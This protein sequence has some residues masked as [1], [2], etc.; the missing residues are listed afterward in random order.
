MFKK[1]CVFCQISSDLENNDKVLKNGKKVFLLPDIKP[2]SQGHALIITK[3]H[4]SDLSASS[5]EALEEA[6]ILA[7]E[8]ANSLLKK[9]P[10]IKGFNYIS[11]QGV[12]AK[13]VVFHFHLHVIPRW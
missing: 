12:E 13:Q 6:I 10:E 4:F 8:Y 1:D 9:H 2:I 5:D 7:K 11:N 3:E